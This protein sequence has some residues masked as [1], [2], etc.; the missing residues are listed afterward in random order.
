MTEH[1]SVSNCDIP[2]SIEDHGQAISAVT[3]CLLVNESMQTPIIELDGGKF[4]NPRRVI[5]TETRC[6]H[7]SKPKMA[8]SHK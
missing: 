7:W 2:Q 4:G 6:P 3:V 8:D 5:C 1:L